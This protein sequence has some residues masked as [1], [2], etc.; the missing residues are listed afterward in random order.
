MSTNLPIVWQDKVNSP[1]L[2]AYFQQ[3]G[4]ETYLSAE[5]INQIRD[6][7]NEIGLPD[8][9]I[10]TTPL[11]R[12]DNL[13]SIGA[14]D[15]KW[16]LNK[17]IY[18][19]ANPYSTTISAA[20][21][22]FHRKDIIV[23][24]TSGG[25]NKYEGDDDT[26]VAVQPN[27]PDDTLLVSVID[28]FGA[29]IGTPSF[30]VVGAYI[31]KKEKG[32]VSIAGGG[33]NLTVSDESA[34]F[35]I[36]AFTGAINYVYNQ[37]FSYVGKIYTIKNKTGSN[38]T[39]THNSA[40]SENNKKFF[41]FPNAVDFI[42]KPNEQIDFRETAN[43]RLDFIGV[44]TDISGKQD[45]LTETNFGAFENSLTAKATPLDA[46]FISIV[47]TA[48]SNK[49]KK[50]TFTQMKAFFKTYF[51]GFY[52]DMSTNT[53]QNVS[54]LKTFLNGMFGLRNLANTF[55]SFFT[56]SN[57]ASRTYT[58]QDRDGTIA[59]MLDISA[60]A[61][62]VLEQTVYLT[63]VFGYTIGLVDINKR[64]SFNS[65]AGNTAVVITIPTDAVVNFPIGS[66]LRVV[67]TAGG[68]KT[69]VTG[70]GVTIQGKGTF[71]ELD[72]TL[73]LT[74]VGVNLWTTEYN[75]PFNVNGGSFSTA[76]DITALNFRGNLVHGSIALQE[77][78]GNTK[79]KMNGAN[80]F[81]FYSFNHVVKY[82]SDLSASFDAR[83]FI[84][85]GY[86]DNKRF[87]LSSLNLYA[88]DVAAAAGGVAVGFA[89]INSSTGALQR[90][91]T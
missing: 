77:L 61:A 70:S 41:T 26:E 64:L 83:C 18:E 30:P 37:Y 2:L 19:N 17:V 90:R 51:D 67:R 36:T 21:D 6:A 35:E 45:V 34:F 31:T 25:F 40:S 50:T 43:A 11:T 76:Y 62:Q 33:D 91:L 16:I 58:F 24:N 84:D 60:V 39:I 20:P 12:V 29:T 52:G 23:A 73:L 7:I 44:F 74:K 49:A 47:D 14:L 3:F 82:D 87:D 56:N 1:A 68:G 75:S 10:K 80:D 46:D 5:E 88:N 59:D 63:S 42:L 9:F 85:K 4:E 13:V 48:D 81:G 66:R 54:A 72:V 38:L 86:F 32:V 53:P 27:T 55:T 69:Q 79:M 71:F 89:Y 15:F 22:G 8:G 28:V 65:P 78:S 57:T